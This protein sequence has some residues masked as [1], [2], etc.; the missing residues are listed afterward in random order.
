MT[1]NKFVDIILIAY[2]VLGILFFENIPQWYL[3]ITLFTFVKWITNYRKCTLSYIEI[4]L[5]RVR[6]EDGF[7][8][9]I[10]DSLMN[11]R[12]RTPEIYFIYL[13]QMIILANTHMIWIKAFLP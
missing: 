4:K 9:T 1:S 11:I 6:K 12:N 7:M 3:V 10:L 13:F 2:L 5:R 8:Y